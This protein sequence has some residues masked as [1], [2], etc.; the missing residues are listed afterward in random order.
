MK[1]YV[2]YDLET[3]GLDLLKSAI[4]QI[5][6]LDSTCKI[7]LN[8]YVYP[9][10]NV[11]EGTDI[12]GIDK[13]TLQA[14]N[15]LNATEMCTSIKK[16]LRKK[17]EREDIYWIAYNNFGFDQIILEN[18]FLHAQIKMPS[19]W[20]FIDF[21]PLIRELYPK[22]QPNF[23]LKSVYEYLLKPKHDIQYHSS[24]EDTKCLY[25]IFHKLMIENKEEAFEKYTRC[26]FQDQSILNYPLTAL[27]GYY[28]KMCLEKLNIHKIA[29]LH[30]IYQSM[31]FN[32]QSM[33]NFLNIQCN[34]YVSFLAKNIIRQLNLINQMGMI[35]VSG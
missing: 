26:S 35:S 15:A 5:T 19:N 28:P 2:L 22:I 34:I 29:D 7:L 32:E 1:N 9:Y 3:N 14:N 27:Q 18:N 23:K 30:Y 31:N 10:N 20:Y 11:V 6:M 21:F 4:M 13:D 17:Y 33:Y 16:V 12:H 8:E 24:L 25:D